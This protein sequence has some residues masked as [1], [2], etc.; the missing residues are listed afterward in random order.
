MLLLNKNVFPNNFTLSLCS[1][2]RQALLTQSTMI[3][4]LDDDK[5]FVLNL[6]DDDDAQMPSVPSNDDASA[7]FPAHSALSAQSRRLLIVDDEEILVQVLGKMFRASYDVRTATSGAEGLAILESGFIPKLILADQ[8]MPG[9][10]GAEFLG[11]SRAF[12][13]F[14]TRIVLTGYTDVN[15]IIASIN[16]GNVYRFITKPWNPEELTEA[17]RLGFEHYNIA[18][19][20]T[21]LTSAL[22]RLEELNREQKDL[23]G[24]VAHDL[25]N[26]IG[27]VRMIAENLLSGL[28]NIENKEEFYKLIFDSSDRA[29]QLISDLLNVESLERGE[30]L[31]L[32]PFDV[33]PI[34][35]DLVGQYRV[36]ARAKS[37]T[38]HWEYE[39][40]ALVLG[41]EK[42]FLQVMD[43][44]ISNAVKYSPHGKTITVG[45]QEL[46]AIPTAHWH[47]TIDNTA[48]DSWICLSV[49]D[50]GPGF[51]DEDKERVFGKFAKLSARPTGG[52]N[53]TGLGLSIVKRYVEAMQGEIWFHSDYGNGATF[54]VALLKSVS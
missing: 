6:S 52:E 27:A 41:V 46:S 11:K 20:N 25:K 33:Q 22:K 51:T 50:E 39:E 34:I 13:P 35:A 48:F 7:G 18:T 43:N 44:L 24:I 10:S 19:R 38:L 31:A 21:E 53:A 30:E 5:D 8:R 37:I 49:S 15:D 1:P 28:I 17:V 9:M 36:S 42:A 4:N 47:H 54:Y 26:P 12:A 3:L 29:L 32:F 2:H 16:Q 14:A 45:V 23:M 40:P